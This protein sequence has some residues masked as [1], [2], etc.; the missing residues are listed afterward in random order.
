[1]DFEKAL[2]SAVITSWEE[3]VGSGGKSSIH[4]EYDNVEGIPVA[5]LRVWETDKG[6]ENRVCDYSALPASAQLQGIQFTNAHG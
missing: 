1:M 6:H 2:E 3:L 5:S 4:V